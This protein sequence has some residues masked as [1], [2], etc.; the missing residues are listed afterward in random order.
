ML[1]SPTKSDLALKVSLSQRK[2]TTDTQPPVYEA[3]TSRA[4]KFL[5]A[6][7]SRNHAQRAQR[8]LVKLARVFPHPYN[9]PDHASHLF[10]AKPQHFAHHAR[11]LLH[12]PHP[13]INFLNK[14]SYTKRFSATNARSHSG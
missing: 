3:R 1:G 7:L 10:L 13:R 8:L 6:R 14:L 12:P 9:Y 4:G 11:I 5:V 2:T